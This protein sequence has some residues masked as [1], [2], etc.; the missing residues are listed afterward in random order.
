MNRQDLFR[1]LIQRNAYRSYLE[2][3][4][5]T[6]RTFAQ[7][8]LRRKVGVDP[9]HGGT[10]RMTSDEFFAQNR[11]AFDLVFVDGLHLCEQVLRDV[12]NAVRCLTPGGCI[13]RK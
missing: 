2:I 3:G 9:R 11:E 10:L 8:Q 6:A 5:E 7:V 13:V 4:C 12:D 1:Y